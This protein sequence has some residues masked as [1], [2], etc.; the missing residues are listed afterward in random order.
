MPIS[1]FV[2]SLLIKIDEIFGSDKFFKLDSNF[3]SFCG[4]FLRTKSI[5][6]KTSF[7]LTNY[8]F[9]I[10]I[11]TFLAILLSNFCWEISFTLIIFLF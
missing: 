1:D 6:D 2:L 9:F 8:S 5:E 3:S 11:S 10:T 4:F 7:H